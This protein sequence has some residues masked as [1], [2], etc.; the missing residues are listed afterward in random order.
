MPIQRQLQAFAHAYRYLHTVTYPSPTWGH[1]TNESLC[2]QFSI[3][4]VSAWWTVPANTVAWQKDAR[5]ET[6]E[7]EEDEEAD[8]SLNLERLPWAWSVSN[9]I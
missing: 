4:N 1:N 9:I 3:R 7:E 8:E 2:G 5:N 6:Q